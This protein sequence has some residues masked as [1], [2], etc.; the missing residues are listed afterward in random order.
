[1]ARVG[2]ARLVL[3]RAQGKPEEALV[4]RVQKDA[5]LHAMC[6]PGLLP[7]LDAQG[8]AA[9]V[10]NIGQ[11]L[12]HPEHKA[13]L[14]MLCEPPAP[15]KKSRKS[16][17]QKY[18][19]QILDFFRA[20]EWSRLQESKDLQGIMSLVIDR[21]VCLGGKNISERCSAGLVSCMLY[22]CGAGGLDMECKSRLLGFF[23]AEHK[24]RVRRLPARQ[25]SE[26]YL[27]E[28][29]PPPAMQVN[30]PEVF[31]KVFGDEPPVLAR[32]KVSMTPMP[33]VR[34]RVTPKL[35]L[36]IEAFQRQ[37]SNFALP[38]DLLQLM[39]AMQKSQSELINLTFSSSQQ[40]RVP[41]AAR[42]LQAMASSSSAPL[43]MLSRLFSSAPAAPVAIMDATLANSEGAPQAIAHT[44]EQLHADA[45]FESPS[46]L[47]MPSHEGEP[48]AIVQF[49]EQ[50]HADAVL[51]A[52]SM[53]G[54]PSHEGE[55]E[56]TAQAEE[57]LQQGDEVGEGARKIGGR[58]GAHP[59][60]SCAQDATPI[61]AKTIVYHSGS[62]AGSA[63]S[64]VVPRTR[65]NPTLLPLW[66]RIRRPRLPSSTCRIPKHS[67][68]SMCRTPKRSP[69]LLWWH[70]TLPRR[71]QAQRCSHSP[72]HW[73]SR[74]SRTSKQTR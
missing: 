52:P 10:A 46:M 51:G 9:P 21:V 27:L 45:G 34:C 65:M 35:K 17:S 15:K 58:M 70:C 12:F 53:L 29:L 37:N 19:P 40:Q 7:G 24:R 39:R 6:Q 63:Q 60:T 16:P 1:M 48:Q 26:P 3:G 47:G 8:R 54:E 49:Q 33:D 62:T 14:F 38:A 30:F 61:W 55:T 69:T 74:S 73:P 23:K 56:A 2:C 32:I 71:S 44:E 67:P 36:E 5:V 42:T 31:S 11:C 20:S 50:L 66:G 28:L 68:S 22:M 41:D 59:T 4:S 43:P 13:E 64:M 18:Y 25:P 72:S 57:Q